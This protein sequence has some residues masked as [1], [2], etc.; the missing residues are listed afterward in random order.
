MTSLLGPQQQLGCQ[1]DLLRNAIEAL[2]GMETG[3]CLVIYRIRAKPAPKVQNH[4]SYSVLHCS[5]DKDIQHLR[6]IS[7]KIH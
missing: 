5:S 7:E 3:R 6:S 4:C 2:A 1:V